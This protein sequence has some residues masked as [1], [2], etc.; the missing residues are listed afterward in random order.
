MLTEKHFSKRK[1]VMPSCWA[2]RVSDKMK[3]ISAEKSDNSKQFV[4]F[5]SAID[6]DYDTM[7]EL[8]DCMEPISYQEFSKNCDTTVFEALSYDEHFPISKDPLVSFWKGMFRDMMT[9]S[10]THSRIEYLFISREAVDAQL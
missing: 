1:F 2:Q 5:V 9:Y 4:F 3:L 6:L 10:V 7:T 8:V